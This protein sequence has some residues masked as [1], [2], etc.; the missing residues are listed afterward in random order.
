MLLTRVANQ[1]ARKARMES[2]DQALSAI[3]PRRSQGAARR[4]R[5]GIN[6][7][8][9]VATTSTL[10]TRSSINPGRP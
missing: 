2:G 3:Y 8:V 9:S 7:Q 10:T 1:S 6:P 4:V 5:S